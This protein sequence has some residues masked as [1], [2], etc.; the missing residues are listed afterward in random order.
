MT[1]IKLYGYAT[2]PFVRK[3]AACLYYKGLDFEHVPVDPTNA[4]ETIGFTGKTQVPVLKIGD[5]WKLDSTPISLWLDQRF[6]ER[7][8]L[9]HD[10]AMRTKVLEIDDWL[11]KSFIPSFFRTAVDGENNLAFKHVAWRLAALVSAQT[12][13]SD[14]VRNQWPNMLRT[15]PFILHMVE[16]LNREEGLIE[17]QT[18][19]GME[20]LAHLGSGPFLGGSAHPTLVDFAL[21]PILAFPYMAGLSPEMQIDSV[22]ALKTWSRNVADH[23]P[24]NFILIPDDFIVA[25]LG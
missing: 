10:Q 6:P 5:Q 16:N 12:P 4:E 7:P 14:Q 18:R 25:Y 23:L 3:V 1:D 24:K 20:M 21:L 15:A 22:P 17:M 2:S 9:P 13:L 8:L 19:L 11:N